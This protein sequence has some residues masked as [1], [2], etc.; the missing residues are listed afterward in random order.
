MA[1]QIG[2]V[3]V[4]ILGQRRHR[5]LAEAVTVLPAAG[6]LP[7]FAEGQNKRLVLGADDVIGR[8]DAGTGIA[9][10]FGAIE[11]MQDLTAGAE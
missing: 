8:G 10:Q 4:H 3:G 7:A 6:M 11:I 9:R 2:T 1:R 5:R